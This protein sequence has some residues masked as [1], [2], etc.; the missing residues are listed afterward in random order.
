[1][2]TRRIREVS[3]GTVGLA[4]GAAKYGD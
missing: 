1:V 4:E 3:K 2:R